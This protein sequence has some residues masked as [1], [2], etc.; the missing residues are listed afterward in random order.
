[1][2]LQLLF[3]ITND[4]HVVDLDHCHLQFTRYAEQT[5]SFPKVKL[6]LVQGRQHYPDH[7]GKYNPLL[8][9]MLMVNIVVG[10]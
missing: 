7:A 4:C 8:S 10:M 9:L 2:M 5:F 3:E 1:M 6:V